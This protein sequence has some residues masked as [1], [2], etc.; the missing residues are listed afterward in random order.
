M[1]AQ[2]KTN[3]IEQATKHYTDKE[4]A[5][6]VEL[7]ESGEN[8]TMIYNSG[9]SVPAGVIP[10]GDHKG[11]PVFQNELQ[12]TTQNERMKIKNISD[13]GTL[14]MET[15]GPYACKV[16]MP[17][18][19]KENTPNNMN[20]YKESVCNPDGTNP[21]G[22]ATSWGHLVVIPTNIRKYN[23]V[24]LSEG[25]EDLLNELQKVGKQ[26]FYALLNGPDTMVG[27]LRWAM[28]QD[29]TIT[30][31]NGSTVSTKLTI[32]DFEEG[33]SQYTFEKC[34]RE[35]VNSVVDEINQNVKC[36]LHVGDAASIGYLHVHIIAMKM[37][38]VS[39]THMEQQALE[40]GYEKM[41]E[42]DQVI[43]FVKSVEYKR[44][45]TDLPKLEKVKSQKMG[46]S[47]DEEDGDCLLTRTKS[48]RQ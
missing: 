5:Y 29:D 35:G 21:Q 1:S 20:Y 30:L 31:Q 42:V 37:C 16:F 44:L 41:T 6:C 40:K 27:S 14:I 36:F 2:S 3:F 4:K 18:G 46:E 22:C 43:E 17:G 25:D 11:M 48:V 12:E 23:A 10:A 26:A 32:D 15:E 38:L 7:W 9:Q 39:K 33:D 45:K 34:Q 19:N 13:G 8:D 28:K 47:S 24:T